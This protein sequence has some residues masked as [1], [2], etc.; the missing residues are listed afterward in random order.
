MEKLIIKRQIS[1]SRVFPHSNDKLEDILKI[2]PSKSAIEWA[3]YMLTKIYMRSIEQKEHEFFMP[4]LFQMNE[5]LQSTMI[6]YLQSISQ[7]MDDYIFMDRIALL[8]LIDYLLENHNESNVDVFDSKDDFSNMFIAYLL[9]C[10][11]KLR[12]TTK[13]LDEIKDAESFMTSYLPEQLRYNDIY[14]PKDYRVEFLRFYYFMTFCEKNDIFKEY[15]ELF[16]QE[17]K[18][19]KWDDYLYFIFE[20]Y[21]SLATNNEGSTNK[22]EIDPNSYYGKKYLD[23]MSIDVKAHKS[24][25]DFTY[26]R[27]KPIYHHGN[28]TYSII[29]IGFFVDKMFQSFLFDFASILTAHKATTNINGYPSLKSLVGNLF[30]ENYLFYE[31]INGCFA[32]TSKKLLSGVELKGLL[33]DGEPD[34]Y[35]RKSRSVFL[36]EFKDT[37]LNS[38]I[39]HSED[40]EEIKHELF[41]LFE[42]SRV[43]KSAGK[44][45]KKPRSKG[46]T[47]L[48]NTIET[49]LDTIIQNIDRVEA[50]NRF[51]VYP[52]IVYQDCCFD[53]EGVRYILSERFEEKKKARNLSD[54]YLIKPLVMIPLEMMISLEDYFN[55]GRLLL[56]ALI[57]NY[58]IECALSEQNRLIPF[59]KY[60][61]RQAWKLGYKNGMSSR[62]KDVSDFMI[63]KNSAKQ[64]KVTI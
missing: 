28:N 22:I 51:I 47:Q 33:G 2:I 59:N 23:S 1:Y 14:H 10:D 43:E 9:C 15:L 3:S 4:L 38:K 21:G 32:K 55:D 36:F 35:I 8:T 46:I 18:I 34:F 30:T 16:L 64:N 49:K 37:M 6:N 53:I 56:D 54:K 24:S 5:E 11:E 26:L 57:D 29:S 41:E 25:L 61:M 12:F 63:E 40:I 50:T 17:N 19:N 20:T 13:I 42:T 60:I 27:A 39:K 31:I 52:I 58:I 7:G 44:L 48:L 45:K 62:F